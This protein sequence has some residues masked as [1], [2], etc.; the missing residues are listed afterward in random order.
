MKEQDTTVT[1]WGGVETIGG[2]IV[3]F[4]KGRYCLITDFGAYVGVDIEELREERQTQTLLEEGKLPP[5]PDFYEDNELHTIVCLTHLHLDHLGSLNH[6][7]TNVEIWLS[8][9]AY[10][11]YQALEQSDYLPTYAVKWRP[12]EWEESLN[13]GPF[14]IKFLP[15]DHDTLGSAAIFVETDDLKVI[16]SGDFRL[17]GFRPHDVWQWV[18]KARQFKPDFLLIEG[19]AFSF[20]EMIDPPRDSIEEQIVPFKKSTEKALVKAVERLCQNEEVIVYN[21]YAQ[22]IERLMAL[23]YLMNQLNRQVVVSSRMK[24]LLDQITDQ[25]LKF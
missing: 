15:S 16:Q 23:I 6:L 19:T 5:I 8:Q 25:K 12:V 20:D 9:E 14:T 3:S 24:S 4:Q 22:N 10:T 1:F 2:S 7:P 18:Q 13:F 17:S 21:G 11:F